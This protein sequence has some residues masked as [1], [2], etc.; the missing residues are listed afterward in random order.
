MDISGQGTSAQNLNIFSLADPAKVFDPTRSTKGSSS[1]PPQQ[2]TAPTDFDAFMAAW[3][4]SN[5]EFD[6]DGS[7]TVDGADLGLF[8]SQVEAED[9]EDS[10]DN[11][12]SL[13]A[14]F[15][16]DE[17]EGLAESIGQISQ[18]L[19]EPE[20]DN[21]IDAVRQQYAST[22]YSASEALTRANTIMK[23]IQ[24]S[25]IE[26]NQVAVSATTLP[27]HDSSGMNAYALLARL[28]GNEGLL[29]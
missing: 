7:G 27:P 11:L 8:L 28:R 12:A 24:S 23:S 6:L 1:E 17:S 5:A 10:N 16:G 21:A 20:I 29:M 3:G 2:A 15:D 19:V 18:Q 13:L 26:M 4:T 22:Q 14:P 25:S 9:E